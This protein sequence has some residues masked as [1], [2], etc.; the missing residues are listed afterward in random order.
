MKKR[1]AACVMMAGLFVTL[2]GGLPMRASAS[3]T[4]ANTDVVPVE[5]DDGVTIAEAG[6]YGID[7]GFLKDYNYGE[8]HRKEALYTFSTVESL[9]S[10]TLSNLKNGVIVYTKGYYH[11][12]DIGR[13]SYKIEKTCKT[14]G[15]ELANGLYANLM[16]DEYT[17]AEGH[18]WAVVN[19]M[20]LGAHGDGSAADN[21]AI[22]DCI[23]LAGSFSGEDTFYRAMAYLP[24]GEYKCDDKIYCGQKSINVCG[25]GESTIL[26]TDNDYR[27]DSGYSEFFFEVWGASDVYFGDFTL[28]GREVDLY[29]YMRQFVLVYSHNIYV[30][31]VDLLIPQE[32]YHSYYFQDKQYSNFCCYCGNS[33]ITVDDCKMVQMSGTYRGANVGV[34]DI[35]SKGEENITIMNCDLYG[36]AR[37]EQIGFFSTNKETAFVKNVD[38]INNTIHAYEPKYTSV[39]GNAT[40]RFTIAYAD[41]VGVDDI[42]IA[43]N[44]FIVECD[45]KFITFGAVTNC[46]IEKNIM[47]IKCTYKTWSMVFD[48]ANKDDNNILI[49]DNDFYLSSDENMGKG[50]FIGGRL[51]FTKNRVFTDVPLAF[52]FMGRVVKDNEF[53]FLGNV[54][55]FM[56]VSDG[57]KISG[58]TV[59]SYGKLGGL[60]SFSAD[61]DT[62]DLAFTD[63]V[64]YDYQRNTSPR[65]I[66]DAVSSI[67]AKANSVTF[68]DNE[69]YAPNTILE[70]GTGSTYEDGEKLSGYSNWKRVFYYRSADE[71]IVNTINCENNILQGARGYT[72]YGP[73][74]STIYNFKNNQYL[75]WEEKVE[76]VVANRVEVSTGGKVVTDVST[77]A[78]TVDLDA[79]VYLPNEVDEEG[80]VLSE[81]AASDRPVTWYTTVDSMASVSQDGVVNRKIYG[82]V[83]IYAVSPDGCRN[84]GKCVVHFERAEAKDIVLKNDTIVVQ[85]GLREY[86]E[87]Q[88]LPKEASQDVKW[89]SADPAVATVLPKGVVTG[90]A[91]GETDLICSTPD[92]RIQKKVRVKV[93]EVTVKKI[94]MTNAYKYI[95][96]NE[97]GNTYQAG[98]SFYPENAVNKTVGKWE[99][100]NEEIAT[101]DENGLVTILR[102][103]VVHIRAYSSDLSCYGTTTLYIQ[104]PTVSELTVSKVADTTATLT[105]NKVEGIEGYGYNVYY[106]V[107]GE[108]SWTQYKAS[109]KNNYGYTQDTYVNVTGLTAGT[110]YEFLVRPFIT[111]WQSGKRE[112]HEAE[113]SSTGTNLVT[114]TTTSYIP[115]TKISVGMEEYICV[116]EGG[117]KEITVTYSEKAN[118]S[119]LKMQCSVEAPTVAEIPEIITSETDNTL[120]ANQ[121]K[122][123]V[124]GIKGGLTNLIVKSN[125]DYGAQLSL[126]VAVITKQKIDK[127]SITQNVSFRQV[128]VTFTGLE[129][130]SIV[131]GYF[132]GKRVSYHYDMIAYI[133]VDGSGTYHFTQ[134]T[135]LSDGETEALH[136]FPAWY[137]GK[138][139]MYQFYGGTSVSVTFPE[140][141]T[142]EKISL[143][144][145]VYQI[146]KGDSLDIAALLSRE[147]QEPVSILSMDW[148][149]SNDRIA[150]VNR[151][152]SSTS[153]GLQH[154]NAKITGKS[155]GET[156]LIV[157]ATDGS[158]VSTTAKLIVTP[159]KVTGI[160]DIVDSTSVTLKWNNNPDAAGYHIYR[161][162]EKK[163]TFVKVGETQNDSYKDDG[164]QSETTY[165]YQVVPYIAAED[166]TLYEG[167]ISDAISVETIK[168]EATEPGNTEQG[169]TEPGATEPEK[170]ESGTTEQSAATKV[171]GDS[172]TITSQEENGTLFTIG[173][174]KY[175]VISKTAVSVT[176]CVKKNT[177]SL[178]IKSTV[179]ADGRTYKVTSI[180][181]NAFTNCKKVK[182]VTIGTNVQSIGS[183]AFYRLSKLKK[184]TIKSKQLKKVGSKAITGVNKEL[185]I[186]VPFSKKKKYQKLFKKSVGFKATMKIS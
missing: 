52:G 174:Y 156:E 181:A 143:E 63:N 2:L 180:A 141:Y 81:T 32:T 84:Y 82:D 109:T 14:G 77:T 126:P 152:E 123:K 40:M 158:L 61:D 178:S 179:K 108:E 142:V 58:N 45:S 31:S 131:G 97:I 120:G 69:Y 85:P 111:N 48:S 94:N 86:L 91:V 76:D 121:I 72:A 3:T 54:G 113:D 114:F 88:V 159:E 125:D 15:I 90:V 155:V 112:L 71:K 135:N 28:E 64:I 124:K 166:G 10:S 103:G 59:Y 51:T 168:Q 161:Y 100:S 47:E 138:N 118:Y 169:T 104:P 23:A 68:S 13:A 8:T 177:T 25:E 163:K 7:T 139:Y 65:G 107:K 27:K 119:G 173:N 160:S 129:D 56:A 183:K 29:N 172:E 171:P 128:D 105:W 106:R 43:G 102:N 22:N 62:A 36:N 176:G 150:S 74:D 24:A 146:R 5:I 20:Q 182:R 12:G 167:E 60:C 99:S 57:S 80:K 89:E 134:T 18:L 70:K 127:D 140:L 50:N 144:Q 6:K 16:A 95:P 26:F 136:I 19:A 162:D 148:N 165:C 133:P 1:V 153:E 30:K 11:P 78:D 164:L 53:V 34:L 73:T 170:T 130:E 115:V 21:Q 35:W 9:K 101:V 33:D 137:D 116:Y 55:K 41:S 49:R 79:L 92:G 110:T 39:V 37:D 93:E 175:K 145:N 96:Y 122:V 157:A 42:H 154:D 4:N 186:K 117:E 17:D 149:I 185:V 46:V 98:V 75:D 147:D 83:T 184:I 151:S 67:G 132:I 66:W 87:Y 38:F 44:H